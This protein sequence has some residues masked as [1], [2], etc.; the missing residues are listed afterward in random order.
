MALPHSVSH[1]GTGIWLHLEH[2]CSGGSSARAGRF[3]TSSVAGVHRPDFLSH[4]LYLRRRL[5][6]GRVRI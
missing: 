5:L 3:S 6:R 4:S 2:A 1:P